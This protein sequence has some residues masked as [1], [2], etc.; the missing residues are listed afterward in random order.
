M[1]LVD[2]LELLL[3]IDVQKYFFFRFIEKERYDITNRHYL[4]WTGLHLAAVSGN[5]ETLKVLLE[6]GADPNAGDEFVNSYRTA[7]EKGLN[8]LDGES[9]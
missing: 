4:G 2:K 5:V 8:A 3:E 1:V 7:S 6:A 9:I